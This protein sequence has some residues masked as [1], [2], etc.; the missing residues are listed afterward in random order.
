MY[1]YMYVRIHALYVWLPALFVNKCVYMYVRIHTLYLW[2]PALYVK[3][4]VY[5]CTCV[6][7]LYIRGELDINV[8]ENVCGMY[9]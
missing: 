6:Y 9:T 5:I 7:I 2:Q 1:V 3:I 8:Y 4:G